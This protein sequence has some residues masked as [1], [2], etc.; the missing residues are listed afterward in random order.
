MDRLISRLTFAVSAEAFLSSSTQTIQPLRTR[1]L[2][3]SVR[4]RPFDK[5]SH[6]WHRETAVLVT[7]RS[8]ERLS[9]QT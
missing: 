1:P 9:C 4:F 3:S 7:D 6:V 2:T 5:G 8:F